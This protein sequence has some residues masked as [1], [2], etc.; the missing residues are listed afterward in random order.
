[1]P[2]ANAMHPFVSFGSTS[3]RALRNFA[4][5]VRALK[6]GGGDN[7]ARYYRK[8]RFSIIRD[9]IEKVDFA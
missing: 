3:T 7:K 2:K 1:M 9:K 8:S 6:I 4:P 5:T